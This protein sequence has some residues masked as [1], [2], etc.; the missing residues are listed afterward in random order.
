MDQCRV[1]NGE[2]MHNALEPDVLTNQDSLRLLGS[3]PLG[4]IA[5]TDRALPAVQPVPFGL[6]DGAVIVRTGDGSKLAALTD[7]SVV[8]FQADLLDPSTYRGWAVTVVGRA[9][10]VTDPDEAKRLSHIVE[11]AWFSTEHDQFIHISVEMVTGWR[12]KP[13]DAAAKIGE[14]AAVPAADAQPAV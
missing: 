7:N 2:A 3:V 12:T 9:E 11:P 13:A 8:A 1:R 10:V 5:Y 14:S 4:R 6:D